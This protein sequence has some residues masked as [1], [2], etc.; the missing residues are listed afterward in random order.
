MV[1]KKKPKPSKR[2]QDPPPKTVTCLH[3]RY[4]YEERHETCPI[5][6]YPWP[7]VEKK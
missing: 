4:E 3:C 6:G 5:C 1:A 7:W 2:K